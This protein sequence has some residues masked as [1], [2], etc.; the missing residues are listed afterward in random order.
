M[1]WCY[2]T[3][4]TKRWEYCN[5]IEHEHDEEEH[6]MQTATC[7]TTNILYK[8]IDHHHYLFFGFLGGTYNVIAM[9]VCVS[10]THHNRYHHFGSVPIGWS[11]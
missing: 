5:P 4:P 9:L 2:T 8:T 1:I 6:K 7:P 3:D 11:H 10:A